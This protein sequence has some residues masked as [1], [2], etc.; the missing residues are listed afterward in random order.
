MTTHTQRTAT[1]LLVD[2]EPDVTELYATWLT[3]DH[4]VRTANG[5]T[6]ALDRVDEAVDVIL[7]DRQMP[8]MTGDE[9]LDR[10]EST[11][12]DCRVVMVTAVDPDYDIVEMP[13]DDYLTKPVTREDLHETVAEMLARESYDETVQQY[14]A[15]ASKKA[16]L[17]TQKSSAELS[18]HDEY[19]EISRRVE[20]L[21]EQADPVDAFSDFETAF[22]EVTGG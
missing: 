14:F 20:Q 18:G 15:V 4:E 1:V 22:G 12:Y 8:G 16:T 7:L 13:F 21:R 17:E 6:E 10:I 3:G 5:G 19:T 9:V 2:D 11:D